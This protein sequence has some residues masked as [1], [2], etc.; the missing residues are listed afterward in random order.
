MAQENK[1]LKVDELEPGKYYE[2][3]LSGN[4]V[5]VLRRE[6]SGEVLGRYYNKVIGIYEDFFIADNQLR[7]W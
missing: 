7:E 2:D 5:L 4:S 3:V 6:C 1:L